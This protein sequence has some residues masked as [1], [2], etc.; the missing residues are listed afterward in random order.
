MDGVADGAEL[1][2]SGK[3]AF[4][5]EYCHRFG[6]RYNM[7]WWFD[8]RAEDGLAAQEVAFQERAGDALRSE[9]WRLNVY[10]GVRS[11]EEVD[12][13]LPDGPAHVLITR[14]GTGGHGEPDV[15]PFPLGA[16][17]LEESVILLMRKAPALDPAQATRLARALHRRPRCSAHWGTC[18]WA[19]G[20]I[21]TWTPA[22]P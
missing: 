1:E 8:C 2:H 19:A 21:W 17:T 20:R 22:S 10:D 13:H 3:T 14:D 9:P 12:G 18:C 4:A 16:L 6:Q 15:R 7:I 11:A 5:L